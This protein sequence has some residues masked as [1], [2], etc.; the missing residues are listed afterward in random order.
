MKHKNTIKIIMAL[1]CLI[2]AIGL[3]YL[4]YINYM[5]KPVDG[6]KN[7]TVYVVTSDEAKEEFSIST[8]SEFLSEALIE[9]NL[10]EGTESTYG[11][12]IEKVNGLTA[13]ADNQEWWCL[14]KFGEAL[15]AGVSATPIYDGDVFELT[16]T[17]GW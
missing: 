17:V 14:T 1:I 12:F 3:V 15:T 2:V 6:V 16:L 7:I 13:N 8:E 5:D 11:F 10:I 9:E 4:L